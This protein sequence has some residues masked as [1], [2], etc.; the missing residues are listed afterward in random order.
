MSSGDAYVF[1]VKD[2]Q[3][4]STERMSWSLSRLLKSSDIDNDVYSNEDFDD[5]DDDEDDYEKEEGNYILN[6]VM[7]N[8]FNHKDWRQLT[9]EYYL[10]PETT[11]QP[12][13]KEEQLKILIE[14]LS[15]T[16]DSMLDIVVNCTFHDKGYKIMRINFNEDL[17]NNDP[18]DCN[19]T[20]STNATLHVQGISPS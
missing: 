13:I 2:G 7:K 20:I 16:M 17:S 5:D 15:N 8:P 19:C 6:H 12:N 10:D 1:I 4:N 11:P 18:I 3:I 14:Q 9:L